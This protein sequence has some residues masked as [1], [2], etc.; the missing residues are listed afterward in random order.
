MQPIDIGG[1]FSKSKVLGRDAGEKPAL[2]A[3]RRVRLVI[4]IHD[5][6]RICLR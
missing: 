4:D 5:L 2:T 6:E 3:R 1:R